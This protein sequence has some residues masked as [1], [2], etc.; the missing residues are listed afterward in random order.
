MYHSLI[1]WSL[2]ESAWNK[3]A[4]QSMSMC[5]MISYHSLTIATSRNNMK[6]ASLNTVHRS[7]VHSFVI[8]HIT[9]IR[10]RKEVSHELICLCWCDS[11]PWTHCEWKMRTCQDDAVVMNND[12]TLKKNVKLISSLNWKF[13][14]MLDWCIIP[15]NSSWVQT[16]VSVCT[17]C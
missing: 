10:I 11:A 3:T 13:K 7:E 17:L 1:M 16:D 5:E 12:L 15:A 9:F 6:T 14:L 4:M 2:R 8:R